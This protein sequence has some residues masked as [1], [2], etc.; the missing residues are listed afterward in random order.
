MR[1]PRREPVDSAALAAGARATK[2]TNASD[3]ARNFKWPLPSFRPWRHSDTSEY[4]PCPEEYFDS[5]QIL[6]IELGLISNIPRRAEKTGHPAS[7]SQPLHV[8]DP[9]RKQEAGHR[10]RFFCA[11]RRGRPPA[12]WG[13]NTAR[14]DRAHRP[15]SPMK[16]FSWAAV[17]NRGDQRRIATGPR[18]GISRSASQNSSSKEM[19]DLSPLRTTERLTTDEFL[20]PCEG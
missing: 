10:K 15:E 12:R 2:R 3:C 18:S 1:L 16:D 4:Q 6:M 8:D 19:L 14:S 20:R 9:G 13:V 7:K 11:G 17:I 5:G